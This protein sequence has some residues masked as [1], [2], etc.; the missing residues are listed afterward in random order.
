LT[1]CFGQAIGLGRSWRRRPLANGECYVS[2]PVL[3][4]I[5]VDP[6]LGKQASLS[7]DITVCCPVSLWSNAESCFS[8]SFLGTN[9]NVLNANVS[10][11]ASQLG[12][13]ATGFFQR[14]GL[15]PN[16]QL[17]NLTANGTN[18][19]LTGKFDFSLC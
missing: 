11:V 10:F 16:T 6:R 14:F 17:S 1:D 5:G 2:S 4:Q 18:I 8:Q 12:V 9:N 3:R 13:N 15:D 19:A 7:I